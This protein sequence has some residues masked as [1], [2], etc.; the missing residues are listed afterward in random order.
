[1]LVPRAAFVSVSAAALSVC[2]LWASV[3]VS[4]ESFLNQL[5]R[6]AGVVRGLERGLG[7]GGGNTGGHRGGG[8][9]HRERSDH[10]DDGNS[11]D[12][13]E[14]SEKSSSKSSSGATTVE[15]AI[16]DSKN[17]AAFQNEILERARAEKQEEGRNVEKAIT[18]LIDELKRQHQRILEDKGANVK[19]AT[20]LDINQ[21]TAGELRPALED[22]YRQSKLSSFERYAGELWTRDRLMVSVVNQ[23]KSGLAPYF[24]GVGA[25][26]PTMTQIKELFNNSSK[27]MYARALEINEV[28]GVSLGFDRFVR[29]MYENADKDA[30]LW[31]PDRNG[32]FEQPDSKY[33]RVAT[34]MI[35]RVIEND[36]TVR[37]E[38]KSSDNPS[39][40]KIDLIERQFLYRFRA[41]RVIYDCLSSRYSEFV[42]KA[43]SGKI[44]EAG[45]TAG[46][47]DNQQGT[48]V[49]SQKNVPV[50]KGGD[51]QGAKADDAPLTNAFV[52]ELTPSGLSK[53]VLGYVGTFCGEAA[54]GVKMAV[55]DGDIGPI[56][57]REDAFARLAPPTSMDATPASNRIDK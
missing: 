35:N 16:T 56:S 42:G 6:A 18:G 30:S 44:I 37:A 32:R 43:P 51:K 55:W 15:K 21:I 5:N 54:Q 31:E 28:V 26:G 25:R 9:G 12:D 47:G 36:P 14:K 48:S 13:S 53:R 4:A 27:E 45:Y 40:M 17:I 41:R 7:N 23:A 2:S 49:G 8:G 1:M 57:A 29:T 22:A 10:N 34:L 39:L 50:L 20:G 52:V 19:A 38:G 33:E 3:P 11:N 46:D 24:E